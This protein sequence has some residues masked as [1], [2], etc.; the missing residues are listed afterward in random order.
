VGNIVIKF[1][2]NLPAA[3][4][5]IVAIAVFTT[6]NGDTMSIFGYDHQLL[7]DWIAATAIAP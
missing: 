4:I 1:R 3:C 5:D 7:K 6:A 2:G